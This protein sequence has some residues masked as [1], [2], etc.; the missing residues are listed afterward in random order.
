MSDLVGN[1]EDRF[2]HNEAQ[3]MIMGYSIHTSFSQ[4]KSTFLSDLNFGLAVIEG[5]QNMFNHYA[6]AKADQFPY[7]FLNFQETAC[8]DK[9]SHSYGEKGNNYIL[10]ITKWH[11]IYRKVP[12]FWDARKLCCNLPKIQTKRPNLMVFC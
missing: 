9:S 8:F 7:E 5:A 12:K 10:N 1:L 6:Y 2:S 4:Q 11:H 3:M